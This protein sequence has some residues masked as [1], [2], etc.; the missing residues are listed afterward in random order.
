[1]KLIDLGISEV[2][3]LDDFK[4]LLPSYFFESVNRIRYPISPIE[5]TKDYVLIQPLDDILI[6]KFHDLTATKLLPAIDF[7][8]IIYIGSTVNKNIDCILESMVNN[9]IYSMIDSSLCSTIDCDLISTI[10]CNIE[11]II[12]Y[13]TIWLVGSITP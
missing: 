12:E 10:D 5:T 11:L 7:D 4:D 1:M 8:K 6:D 3:L 13:D 2:V 9:N